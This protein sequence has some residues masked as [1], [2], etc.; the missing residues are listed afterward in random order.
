MPIIA[1]APES[2]FSPC[3]EGL[4]PAVCVDVVDMGVQQ[5]PWGDKHKVCL[6]FQISE[7]D[8]DTGKPFEVRGYYTLSLSEKANLRKH[9]ETWRGR[10]FTETELQGFDVETVL[11]ANC[12]LQVIHNITDDGKVYSNIQAIV[13]AAKGLPKL[14]ALDYVR[15]KDRAKAH[16]NGVTSDELDA[17]SIPF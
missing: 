7:L 15:M 8:E 2:K 16:G 11:G 5:T 3:P 13:P 6:V 4:H 1:K 17:D 10:K 9:L 12:Q 14:R